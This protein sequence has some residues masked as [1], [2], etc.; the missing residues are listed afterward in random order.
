LRRDAVEVAVYGD[1][2]FEG[3]EL[4]KLRDEGGAVGRISG[5]LILDLSHQKLHEL[6]L[7][8]SVR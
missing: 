5:V 4:R 6:V 1:E 7:A 3:T 8:D 2:L